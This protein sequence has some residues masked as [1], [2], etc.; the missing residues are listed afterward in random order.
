MRRKDR[1]VEDFERIR[2]IVECCHVVR[3]GMFDEEYPYVVPANFGYEWQDNDLILF[4][5]GAK[6]GKK[7]DCLKKNPKVCIELDGNHQLMPGGKNAANCSYAYHSFI[8][9]GEADFLT[10]LQEKKRGL[11]LL[12][13]HEVKDAVYDMPMAIVEKTSVVKIKVTN[14]T[15]KEHPMPKCE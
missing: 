12:M 8:G 15:A 2:E 13:V 10:G 7:V 4:I 3:I 5:H 1:I 14:F 11:D 9:Y 6:A